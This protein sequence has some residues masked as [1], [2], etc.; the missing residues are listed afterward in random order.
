MRRQFIAR[1]APQIIH[2]ELVAEIIFAL[3]VNSMRLKWIAAIGAED[4]SPPAGSPRLRV[5]TAKG[6]NYFANRRAVIL[7]VFD[8][9]M[10]E[11]QVKR[12]RGEGKGFSSRVEDVR[13]IDMGFGG[14]LK[15]IFQSQDSSTKRGEMF[16]IHA[17]A[18]AVFQNISLD[19]L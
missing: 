12:R 1:A 16:D 17:H 7:Y 5:G 15:V 14:A 9:F 11:N 13:R 8:H 19:A 18:A 2:K 10:A 4:D 3:P 6:T